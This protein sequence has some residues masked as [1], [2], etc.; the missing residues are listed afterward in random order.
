MDYEI[1]AEIVE[2][3]KRFGI[4]VRRA[5]VNYVGVEEA[6]PTKPRRTS[7]KALANMTPE[8]IKKRK[9]ER[10]LRWYYEKK[11]SDPNLMEKRRQD[12]KK[13]HKKKPAE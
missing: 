4:T 5:P 10:A 1:D 3:N 2:K 8:E 13:W 6:V 9:A 11:K 12:A 7:S